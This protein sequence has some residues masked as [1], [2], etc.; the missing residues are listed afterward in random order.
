MLDGDSGE[1]AADQGEAFDPAK[2]YEYTL[3]ETENVPRI[4]EGG[5]GPRADICS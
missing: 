5:A 4:V 1:A 2:F 3:D